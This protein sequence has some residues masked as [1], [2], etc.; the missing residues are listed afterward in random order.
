MKKTFF[1]IVLAMLMVAGLQTALAQ[2][3]IVTLDDG[4]RDGGLSIRPVRK[5]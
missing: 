4:S 5:Q 3:M 2:K 1:L